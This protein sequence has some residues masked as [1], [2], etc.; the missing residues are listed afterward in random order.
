MNDIFSI[1]L[2]PSEEGIVLQQ[3]TAEDKSCSTI[4]N[5]ND[6]IYKKYGGK[7]NLSSEQI[8]LVNEKFI[9]IFLRRGPW[10]WFVGNKKF[11]KS[12][13]ANILIKN[14]RCTYEE[15]VKI[16]DELLEKRLN[17]PSGVECGWECFLSDNAGNEHF[18]YRI[19][20][21]FRSIL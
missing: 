20:Y 3:Q 11:T 10:R 4:I 19:G 17:L 8:K 2:T 6:L 15:A 12:E 21:Y 9:Q 1:S 14:Y 13:I 16:T 18:K 7:L 5:L